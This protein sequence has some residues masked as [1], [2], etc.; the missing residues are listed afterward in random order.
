MDIFV[1]LIKS[2]GQALAGA[3]V[4]FHMVKDICYRGILKVT[5]N[6][7]GVFFF[8]GAVV[9][10]YEDSIAEGTYLFINRRVF[11]PYDG[12]LIQDLL[13]ALKAK[14][15]ICGLHNFRRLN[16]IFIGIVLVAFLCGIVLAYFLNQFPKALVVI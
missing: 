1:E 2:L 4:G 5:C 7:L 16:F 15:N 10:I 9:H 12:K 6:R 13:S 3:G 11:F 14:E 8:Q